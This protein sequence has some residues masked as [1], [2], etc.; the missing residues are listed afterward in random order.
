MF[1]NF[2]H[3]EQFLSVNRN[4][5]GLRK[6]IVRLLSIF[7]QVDFPYNKGIFNNDQIL[8]HLDHFL[9]KSNNAKLVTKKD[10]TKTN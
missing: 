2:Q 1:N 10:G 7:V 8:F 6:Y 5:I 3:I 9:S 4:K